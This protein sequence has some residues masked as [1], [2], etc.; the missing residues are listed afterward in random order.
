MMS[1]TYLLELMHNLQHVLSLY[2]LSMH[3]PTAGCN[4]CTIYFTSPKEAHCFLS[5]FSAAAKLRLKCIPR[6]YRFLDLISTC[7]QWSQNLDQ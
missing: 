1:V 2:Q 3:L 5:K 6:L 7:L 4:T